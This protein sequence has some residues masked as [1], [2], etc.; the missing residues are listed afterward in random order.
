MVEGMFD[1]NRGDQNDLPMY[2][3]DTYRELRFRGY[4][5]RY[6]IVKQSI[7]KFLISIQ[8][9]FDLKIKNQSLFNVVII[10]L[11]LQQ[12]IIIILFR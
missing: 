9:V 2:E 4:H 8:H 1:H 11:P 6:S 5:Y 3:N 12:F 10:M 7:L